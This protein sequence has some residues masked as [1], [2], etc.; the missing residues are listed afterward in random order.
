MPQNCNPCYNSLIFFE[1]IESKGFYHPSEGKNYLRYEIETGFAMKVYL[2]NMVCNRCIMVVKDE[3]EKIGISPV[4]VQLGEVETSEEVSPEKLTELANRLNNLGFELIDNVQ[5]RIIEK[6][7]TL[8]IQL[9]HYNNAPL[10]I[11]HSDYIASQLHRDYNYLSNLFS[12]IEGITIEKY[13]ILQKVE[14]VKEL[15]VYG[16]MTLSEIADKMGYSSV[17]YLSNQFKKITGLTPSHFK[18]LRSQ[19]RKPLDQVS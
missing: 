4:N 5:S 14:K 12:E 6:I 10:N 8:I 18:Q 16:E 1:K 13:I 17:A 2:K 9:I 3:F 19:K 15:L 7:K 11:N